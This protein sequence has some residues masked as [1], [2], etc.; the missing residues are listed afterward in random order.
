MFYWYKANWSEEKFVHLNSSRFS[1]RPLK[2]SKIRAYSNCDE[3]EFFCNGV[4]EGRIYSQNHI[5][6]LNFQ[7]LVEGLNKITAKGYT[8]DGIVTS[9]EFTA[10]FSSSAKTSITHNTIDKNYINHY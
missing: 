9:D 8:P 3:V 10:L 5:F 6:E 7:N 4:S 1:P 2:A